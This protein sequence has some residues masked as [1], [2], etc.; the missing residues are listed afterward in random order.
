M[1]KKDVV[2]RIARS[3]EQDFSLRAAWV[4]TTELEFG[5]DDTARIALSGKKEKFRLSWIVNGDPGEYQVQITSPP[6]AVDSVANARKRKVSADGFGAGRRKF[7][8][9]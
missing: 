6:E 2:I 4:E 8:V 5:Q 7:K 9:N 1:A 3:D